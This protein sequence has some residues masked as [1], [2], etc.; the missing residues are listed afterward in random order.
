MMGLFALDAS[1]FRQ[2]LKSWSPVLILLY[3]NKCWIILHRWRGD[4]MDVVFVKNTVH[5]MDG[6]CKQQGSYYENV[7]QKGLMWLESER[8]TWTL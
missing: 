8:D 6:S 3:H 1:V 7:Q 5:T 2:R 4:F